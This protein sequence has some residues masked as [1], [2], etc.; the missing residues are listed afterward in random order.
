MEIYL[1]KFH[2]I[3]SKGKNEGF[4]YCC[5]QLFPLMLTQVVESVYFI[6]SRVLL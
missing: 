1:M 2:I 5:L 3:Y 6:E 4:Y